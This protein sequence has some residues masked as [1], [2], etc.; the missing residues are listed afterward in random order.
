MKNVQCYELFGGIAL[1]NHAFFIF[2]HFHFIFYFASRSA[3]LICWFSKFYVHIVLYERVTCSGEI[4]LKN[5]SYYY[6]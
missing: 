4:S 3:L 6:I 5:K 1:R 2:F